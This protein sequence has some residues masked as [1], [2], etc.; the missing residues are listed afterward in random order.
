MGA[1]VEISKTDSVMG[2][3]IGDVKISYKLLSSIELGE[4]DIPAII[5]ELPLLAV[6]AT[7]AVGITKI[8]GAEELRV[9][10]SDR[11]HAV[12]SN[13]SKMGADITELRD[14]FIIN[15][16]TKLKGSNI[17]TFGD[18]RIAM[19]FKIAGLISDG[20]NHLDDEKCIATSFP[21]FHQYLDI[22]TR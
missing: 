6:L 20:D 12:C 8:L 7:Q 11:I 16:P 10:E 2:E 19:A 5:D 15:G 9:K 1:D 13:L 4:N 21:E 3:P 22:L 18:H 14:G 17:T